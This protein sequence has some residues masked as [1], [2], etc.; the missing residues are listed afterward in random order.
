MDALSYALIK[1]Y[2]E[3]DKPNDPVAFVRQ[4]FRRSTDE[5]ETDISKKIE[6]MN[7]NEL[8]KKQEH[9]L[10]LARQEIAKL[11]RTLNSMSSK[12]YVFF[13]FQT[14]FE[15]NK[16]KT[17]FSDLTSEKRMLNLMTSQTNI[18]KYS[19]IQNTTVL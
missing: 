3:V 13:H 19:M 15:Q 17:L 6:D 8:N 5:N 12:S 7:A 1:L 4:H 18:M 9:E 16:T 14:C 10:E 11:Q 2:D